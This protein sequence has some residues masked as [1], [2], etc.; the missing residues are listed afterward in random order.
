MAN[1][2]RVM[3]ATMKVITCKVSSTVRDITSG[4]MEALTRG[5]GDTTNATARASINVPMVVDIKVS[6]FRVQCTAEVI[7]FGL[8]V[9]STR[10]NTK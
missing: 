10:A 4:Q 7:I 2:I 5:N 1:S 8:V 6:G 9:S 3:V